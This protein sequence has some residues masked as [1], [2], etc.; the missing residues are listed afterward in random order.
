MTTS[1][2]AVAGPSKFAL[3]PTVEPA[4][5]EEGSPIREVK[6]NAGVGVDENGELVKV[7]AFLNKLFSMVSDHSTDELIYWSDSGESFFG[8]SGF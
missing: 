2:N 8:M 6:P 5:P 1:L 4:S 7:P 3:S